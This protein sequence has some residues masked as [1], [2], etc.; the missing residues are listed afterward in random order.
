MPVL[1]LPVHVDHRVW[2]L[3]NWETIA[4]FVSGELYIVWYQSIS[5][6][7]L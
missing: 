4:K 2:T 6:T 3:V 1:K 5:K 7:I